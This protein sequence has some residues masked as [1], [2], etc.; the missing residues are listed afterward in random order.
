V[1]PYR[2]DRL[3]AQRV[4]E[5]LRTRAAAMGNADALARALHVST[6]TL[7]RQLHEEGVSLQQLKDEVR[8]D[9]AMDQL[10]RS[11]RPVKQVAQAVGFANE[12]SFARAFRQWTGL[13]PS[14]FRR[15]G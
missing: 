11:A 8:R 1:L 5:L 10:R 9:Q 13:S 15:R 2:R 6:R 14:E 7:H 4:R 3:L 12:K